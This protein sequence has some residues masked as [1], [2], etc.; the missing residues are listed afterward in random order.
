MSAYVTASGE[1]AGFSGYWVAMP[2]PPGSDGPGGLAPGPAILWEW[3]VRIFG[4]P[5]LRWSS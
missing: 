3:S 5:T 4:S 1:T 2:D